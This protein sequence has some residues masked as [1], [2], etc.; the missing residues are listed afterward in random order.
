M[1]RGSEGREEKDR[2]ARKE[3]VEK[4]KLV[5]KTVEKR[6]QKKEST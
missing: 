3:C 5:C 6:E 2:F 4:T 1:R